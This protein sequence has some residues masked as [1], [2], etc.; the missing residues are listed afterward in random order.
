MT[1]IRLEDEDDMAV[2]R[3]MVVPGQGVI[4]VEKAPGVMVEQPCP[5][6]GESDQPGW[7]PGLVPPV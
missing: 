2:L 5:V 6:C 1:H 3:P 7:I 4:Y